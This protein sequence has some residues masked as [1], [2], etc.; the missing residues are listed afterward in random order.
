MADKIVQ[1]TA[2]KITAT[3]VVY[4]PKVVDLPVPK[5]A[6]GNSQP[7]KI[8]TSVENPRLNGIVTNMGEESVPNPYLFKRLNDSYT[9]TDQIR[10][11]YQQ[12]KF[13]QALASDLFNR[14]VDYRRVFQ[15]SQ[16]TND[17]Y[18]AVFVGKSLITQFDTQEVFAKQLSKPFSDLY[19]VIDRPSLALGKS[20]FTQVT[21]SEE[22][23]KVAYLKASS[24]IVVSAEDFSRTVAYNRSF[25]SIADAT[26]DF[27]GAANL[28][29]DQIAQVGKTLVNWVASADVRSVTVDKILAN[30]ALVAEQHAVN[31]AKPLLTQSN[32]IS[33]TQIRADKALSTNSV[34]GDTTRY[35]LG[36]PLADST[37]TAEQHA[38]LLA[39]ILAHPA[40]FSEQKQVYLTKPLASGVTNTDVAIKTWLAQRQ[41]S[42][43][44]ASSTQ[45]IF[46]ASKQLQHGLVSTEQNQKR[47]VKSLV[48][49]FGSI[50]QLFTQV[51]YKR[52]FLDFVASTDDFFGNANVDDDQ[53]ARVGKN[54]LSW[55]LPT[56]QHTT[57]VAKVL[58][59]T[60]SALEQARLQPTKVLLS[61]FGNTDQLFYL[62]G[63]LLNS[64]GV[65]QESQVFSV[66]KL[67]TSG[68][69]STDA[70]NRTVLYNRQPTDLAA[71]GDVSSKLADKGLVTNTA[72]GDTTT[73]QTDFKRI[74]ANAGVTQDLQV[75]S[76]TKPLT[77][78]FASTDVFNRTVLYNRQ[79]TDLAAAG[80]VSSKLA[81]KGLVTNTAVGDTTTTQTDFKRIL[82]SIISN[83]ELVA[84]G[85]QAT[86]QD[87]VI[88]PEQVRKRNT[89]VL[90]TEFVQQD[91][92]QKAPNKALSSQS[93]ISEVLTFFKF[94]NRIF[95]EIA[96]TNDGGVINNQGYFAESYV[97]PGYAGTNTNFS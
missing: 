33:L 73:T 20:L 39:K 58:N 78:G 75:F 97:E 51:D 47:T 5:L 60:Y 26:D 63:K 28:D 21:Y 62:A 80:E 53:T 15:E 7:V 32:V 87:L 71:A 81:D 44:V 96:T 9:G 1:V 76:V 27:Y 49:V 40:T 65:T 30:T 22:L 94:G 57:D 12:T 41:F 6:V 59:T 48:T 85:I 91:V 89:K 79:P 43:L 3:N 67:L 72:V 42:D 13:D 35:Q 66:T 23:V 93:T 18:R 74:L 25:Q 38:S 2:P 68:F 55:L 77:S 19:T 50:D 56:E 37:L 52:S 17:S 84:R 64:V 70:F 8:T 95:S 83:T 92:L 86:K 31:F 16:I 90:V 10:L 29:D 11:R 46:S 61:E 69:A 88:L 14:I 82:N 24:E 4:T 34:L 36:K 45:I 54:V